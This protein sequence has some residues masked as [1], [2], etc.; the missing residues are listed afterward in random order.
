MLGLDTS[1]FPKRG[2]RA[3]AVTEV[4]LRDAVLVSKS[5]AQVLAYLNLRPGGNQQRLKQRVIE[6]GLDTSHFTGQ[7]WNVGEGSRIGRPAAPLAT[8]LVANR[9]TQ[10]SKLRRRLLDAGL[11][12]PECE[13]CGWAQRAFDGRLPL[14]VD[15]VN[16]D[17]DDNRLENLQILCPNC[18]SLQPT[19]R[20]SNQRRR[21]PKQLKLECVA[22][23]LN[24]HALSGG[25]F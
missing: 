15:H 21:K 6:L 12:R 5:Y 2:D 22:R 8:V 16:G 25:K 14:E 13:R 9:P 7:A 20:G 10:S 19:H 3:G 11:K 4:Q 23:D 24:P 18:H 17:H 1:H